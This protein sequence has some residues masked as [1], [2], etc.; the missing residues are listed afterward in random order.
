MPRRARSGHATD[1]GSPRSPDQTVADVIKDRRRDD[2]DRLVSV[3]GAD[4]E[5]HDVASPH[6]RRDVQPAPPIDRQPPAV[7][8][9]PHD[10][11]VTMAD[12]RHLNADARQGIERNAGFARKKQAIGRLRRDHRPTLRG[13]DRGITEIG[14]L[15]KGGT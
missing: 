1:A 3:A 9:R 6:P 13:P 12:T 2:H 8:A 11:R 15:T 7:T 14:K 10:E 4:D 5:R